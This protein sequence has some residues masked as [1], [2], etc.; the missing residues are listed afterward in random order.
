MAHKYE[1]GFIWIPR[2]HSYYYTVLL[3]DLDIT[4]QLSKAQIMRQVTQ[5]VGK[6]KLKLVDTTVEIGDILKVYID[7]SPIDTS[8]TNQL[9]F[10]GKVT[11]PGD[12]LT[13]SNVKGY[14]KSADF[15][16]IT[17][18]E[19]YTGSNKKDPADI[20]KDLI[21]KYTTGYTYNNVEQVGE[22]VAVSWS[23]RPLW[24]AIKGLC[25]LTN[26]NVYLDVTDDLHFFKR[27]SEISNKEALVYGDTLTNVKDIGKKTSDIK[28]KITI[29][30]ETEEGLP[31]VATA[32][33]QN[34]IDKYGTKEKV[35]KDSDLNNQE[36][37]ADR[38]NAELE[39]YKDPIE[40]GKGDG[41]LMPFL[42]PGELIWVVYPYQ[43]I[44]AKYEAYKYKYNLLNETTIIHLREPTAIPAVLRKQKES[45]MQI[46]EIKNPYKLE[47]SYNLSFNDSDNIL[48]KTDVNRT[49]GRIIS[50]SSN[51]KM[52]STAQKEDSD[53]TECQLKLIG[54]N[55]SK[56]NYFISA[57]NG[58]N[59]QE[60]NPD[61]KAALDA[62]GSRLKLKI[63]FIETGVEI[64]EAT[65]LY[66]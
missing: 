42:K 36:A 30:G 38:A 17:V 45:D 54:G 26:Y 19:D 5:G 1:E 60:F 18:T 64:N 31:V 16:D 14:E 7:T 55:I 33:N 21:D 52:I 51:A 20:I 62:T 48:S 22:N 6:F 37:A 50:T 10:K 40:K 49:K 66:S 8:T 39:L 58:I 65:I 12:S 13:I 25:E 11:T 4:N 43:S 63:E 15:L 59:W 35:I 34:S 24:N 41:L 27:G 61:Q 47:S 46:E 9:R 53:I 23:N 57:D 44:H 2:D 28:N 29:Y 3:N 56:A 32:K